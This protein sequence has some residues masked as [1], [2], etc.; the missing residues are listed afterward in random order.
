MAR[1]FPTKNAARRAARKEKR[2]SVHVASPARQPGPPGE[3]RMGAPGSEPITSI[4]LDPIFA[5]VALRFA[6]SEAKRRSTALSATQSQP[7][8]SLLTSSP[9]LSHELGIDSEQAEEVSRLGKAKMPRRRLP[10]AILKQRSNAPQVVD[11]CDVSA[12]DPLLLVELKRSRN[13][14]PVPS[15]WQ[16][17]KDYLSNKKGFEKRPF[18]LPA[19]I[20]ATGIGALRAAANDLRDEQ[21]LKEQMRARVQPKMGRLDVDY[22]KLHDAFFRFQSKPVMSGFG[23]TFFDGKES[24]ATV[25]HRQPGRLSDELQEALGIV[26][27]SPP[28]WLFAMQKLG[29][30]PAYPALRIPGVNAPLPSGAQ[31]GYH[32]GGWGRPSNVLSSGEQNTASATPFILRMD[33]Q[34]MA[35]G[36]QRLQ[37]WGHMPELA[38]EPEVEDQPSPDDAMVD[39]AVDAAQRGRERSRDFHEDLSTM[40]NEEARQAGP[41]RTVTRA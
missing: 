2:A 27:G 11:W 40:I 20:S 3:T 41:K 39:D 36:H 12:S 25:L 13:S 26:P 9:A 17:K 22:Q 21:S 38:V 23:E 30:P 7:A 5:G 6:D 24:E 34:I 31:W 4:E 37:Y 29:P 8:D 33:E 32:A 1:A 10:V 16:A 19:F 18:E 14:V 15:H 28:P 35:P